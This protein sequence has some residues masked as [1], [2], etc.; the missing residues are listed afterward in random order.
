[1]MPDPGFFADCLRESF[2]E[3]VAASAAHR[4]EAV[5]TVAKPRPR[6]KSR[7]SKGKSKPRAATRAAP[8]KSRRA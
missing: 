4:P 7:R 1:M 5:E 6:A 8:R 3:L 2:A